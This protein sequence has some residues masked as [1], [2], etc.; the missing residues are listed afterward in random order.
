I[1]YLTW[2]RGPGFQYLMKLEYLYN[3]SS[4]NDN[5]KIDM[6]KDYGKIDQIRSAS[7]LVLVFQKEQT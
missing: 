5:P 1:C 2:P 6:R 4:L 7:T 3:N